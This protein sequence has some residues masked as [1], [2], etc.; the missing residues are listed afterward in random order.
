LNL[1]F[2]LFIALALLT[3]SACSNVSVGSLPPASDEMNP[4]VSNGMP[5]IVSDEV[6]S[7]DSNNETESI[8]QL[9]VKHR[10]GQT[11]V[12]WPEINQIARYNVYSHDEV[13][14]E[15]NLS[16]ATLING[17]WGSLGPDTSVN[18]Y[19]TPEVSLNF[20]V[21][22]LAAPLSSDPGQA[23]NTLHT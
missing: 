18:R 15:S 22:D 1:K 23:Q 17:R 9:T 11:F 14:S 10:S 5:P 2:F 16:D 8:T 13:I 21:D 7:S 19:A 12:L 3:L 6:P 4:T 20:V